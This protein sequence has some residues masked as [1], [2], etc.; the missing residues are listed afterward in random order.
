MYVQGNEPGGQI[1]K[2]LLEQHEYSM[3][4]GNFTDIFY[5][6]FTGFY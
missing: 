6:S 3:K 5:N 2:R 1:E 4:I